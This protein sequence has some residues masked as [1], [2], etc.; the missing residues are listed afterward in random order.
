MKFKSKFF[1]VATEGATTDGRTITA[2]WIQQMAKTFSRAKYGARV[3]LEHM[4]G[5]MPDGPFKAYGDVL[6]LEAR[7]KSDGKL[8]LYAQIEPTDELI[9]MNK[10][11]QKIYSSIEIN[12]DFAGSGEAYLVGLAVTDSPASLGTDMLAFTQQNPEGSPLTAR[13][14]DKDNLFSTAEEI[15]LEFEEV[16]EGSG[17]S[18]RIR[19][20]LGKFRK[21]TVKT[22]DQF[23]QML[24][25]VEQ[26]A[27]HGADLEQRFNAFSTDLNKFTAGLETLTKLQESFEAFKA[28]VEQTDAGTTHRPPAT[29]SD[30][31]VQTDC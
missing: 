4:R 29:G 15:E 19:E 14:Q 28:Q 23:G 25:A 3:W 26:V 21:Q 7:K 9:K 5:L 31:Q 27:S 17:F 24:D 2:E 20:V 12:P 16:D 1:C 8:G 22:E 6:A 11:R 30:G 10:A 13:K 18:E